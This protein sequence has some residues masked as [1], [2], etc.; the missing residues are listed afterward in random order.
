V[1]GVDDNRTIIMVIVVPVKVVD[2]LAVIMIKAI[3]TVGGSV[4]AAAPAA[5]ECGSES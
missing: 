2:C 3:D 4:A 1:V 5:A